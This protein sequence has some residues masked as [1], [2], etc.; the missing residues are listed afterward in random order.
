MTPNRSADRSIQYFP[1]NMNWRQVT[2]SLI[3]RRQRTSGQNWGLPRI[4]TGNCCAVY[5]GCYEWCSGHIVILTGPRTSAGER[6]DVVCQSDSSLPAANPTV[7]P[8]HTY[9]HLTNQ[10]FRSKQLLCGVVA[11]LVHCS[12]ALLTEPSFLIFQTSE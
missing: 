10:V 5:V 3:C 11:G 2:P 6:K 12:A 9:Q 1:I 8:Q 7:Q 4:G